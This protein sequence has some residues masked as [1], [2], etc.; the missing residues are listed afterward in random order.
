[1]LKRIDSFTA[2]RKIWVSVV[3]IFA[4][5]ALLAGICGW[6]MPQQDILFYNATASLPR[7]IYLRIPA[8]TIERGDIVVYDPPE[9][10]LDFAVQRGYTQHKDVRF[11][12][13]VGA[14]AGDVYSIGEHGVFCINGAYIGEVRGLDSKDRPLPQLAQGDYVVSDG[15]FLPIADTTR[16]FDGRYTGTVPITRIRAVVIPVFTQ[17]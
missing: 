4:I 6:Q 7:G 9:T 5:L 14:L 16:S 11:L 10:V 15:M 1:M 17:W 12:K 2:G 3:F 8:A 13:R